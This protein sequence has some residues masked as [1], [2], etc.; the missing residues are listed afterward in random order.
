[1]RSRK[2]S[3]SALVRVSSRKLTLISYGS[4]WPVKTPMKT[5]KPLGKSSKGKKTQAH[6]HISLLPLLGLMNFCQR[7][8][9]KRER[10]VIPDL[11]SDCPACTQHHGPPLQ[12]SSSHIGGWGKG[13]LLLNRGASCLLGVA[14]TRVYLWPE[15]FARSPAEMEPPHLAPGRRLLRLLKP[16]PHNLP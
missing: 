12:S 6:P 11:S 5:A 1:M 9:P 14:S 15:D 4:T 8:T 7:H 10:H 13:A 2:S 16:L 3:S